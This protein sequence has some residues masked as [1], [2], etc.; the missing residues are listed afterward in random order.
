MAS[1]ELVHA[2]HLVHN[3]RALAHCLFIRCQRLVQRATG[4][5]RATRLGVRRSFGHGHGGFLQNDALSGALGRRV[6]QR[7]SREQRL[8]VRVTG[9]VEKRVRLALFDEAAAVHH[10]HAVGDVPDDG[11]VMRY[12]EVA[13]AESGFKICKKIEQASLN[14]DVEGGDR[15][16]EDNQFRFR[17]ES[18]GNI[19]ALA[20]AAGEVTGEAVDV[21][22]VEADE[23]HEFGDTLVVITLV[24]EGLQRFLEDLGNRQTRIE[25]THRILEHNLDVFASRLA[26]SPGE[27]GC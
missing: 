6:S 17:C 11:Q 5:E 2:R 20:L 7:N 13:D 10:G 24:A 26:G 25:G 21:C 12:E 16:V 3:H 19:D 14:G 18:T 27:L 9:V 8:G 22:R 15:L 1:H 23:L 4:D